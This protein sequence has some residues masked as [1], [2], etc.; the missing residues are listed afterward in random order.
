MIVFMLINVVDVA[1][2]WVDFDRV[3]LK[4]LSYVKL[5][6]VI[7]IFMQNQILSCCVLEKKKIGKNL[8]N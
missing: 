2:V 6:S 5:E 3:L 1:R 7:F 4:M 8:L